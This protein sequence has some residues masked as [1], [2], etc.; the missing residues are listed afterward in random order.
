[1]KVVGAAKKR[2]GARTA[3]TTLMPK[4]QAGTRDRRKSIEE[5]A[6]VL[7]VKPTRFNDILGKG[8]DLWHSD[9][10]LE[11]FAED[12]YAHRKEDRESAQQ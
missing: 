11:R 8:S 2:N 10:E 7:G 12:I 1:M 9:L 5:L 6:A 3:T 4:K